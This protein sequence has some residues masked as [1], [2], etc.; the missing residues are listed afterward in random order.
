MVLCTFQ[1]FLCIHCRYFFTGIEQ[2][3]LWSELSEVTPRGLNHWFATCLHEILQL[4][5]LSSIKVA[6]LAR[7][8]SEKVYFLPTFER[9]FLTTKIQAQSA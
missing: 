3:L 9:L 8:T 7:F 1:V 5:L 2:N 6:I 4:E